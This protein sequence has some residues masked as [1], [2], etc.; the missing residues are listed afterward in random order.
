MN[1]M[2]LPLS[3]QD[4]IHDNSQS[5]ISDPHQ[6]SHSGSCHCSLIEAIIVSV[7]GLLLH[8][9]IVLASQMLPTWRIALDAYKFA[10]EGQPLP[11]KSVFMGGRYRTLTAL[12]MGDAMAVVQANLEES[13]RILST[14]SDQLAREFQLMHQR[15][16]AV[17]NDNDANDDDDGV[18][19]AIQM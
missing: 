11:K 19:E 13:L 4:A 5:Y 6:V 15:N 7:P 9:H 8:H 2:T 14:E 1:Q 10:N 12:P 16:V 17:I 3:P 18:G